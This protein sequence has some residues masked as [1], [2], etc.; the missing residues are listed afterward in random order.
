MLRDLAAQFTAV[1]ELLGALTEEDLDRP[2]PAAGWTVRDQIAHLAD[3]EEVAADTVTGGP[4]SFAE[5]VRP[6]PGAD[7]FTAAGVA[8]GAGL[9]ADRLLEWLTRAQDA[10]L[11]AL[12][13]ASPDARVPWALGMSAGTFAQARLMESWAHGWD[14]AQGM[15]RPQ[16]FGAEAWHVASLGHAT[17]AF[18]LRRARARPPAG[19]TLRIDLDGGPHGRW[20][21]G[22]EDASDVISGPAE[23]WVRAATRR[24]A[25]EARHRLGADGPLARLALTHAQAYL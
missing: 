3:T 2:T 9:D 7:A 8:R 4:R 6:Y 10:T 16:R 1:R 23:A 20:T 24:G 17:L 15:G 12:E 14:L 5:A 25:E 18:A 11:A 21:F 19:H 22:P 13:N